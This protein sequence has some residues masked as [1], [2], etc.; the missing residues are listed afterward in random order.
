MVKQVEIKMEV[1]KDQRQLL[2]ALKTI[3]K[4]L[5]SEH[6]K[7]IARKGGVIEVPADNLYIV[8]TVIAHAIEVIEEYEN[9]ASK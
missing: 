9:E 6:I 8:G 4:L 3:H 5:D 2:P 7:D 1:E